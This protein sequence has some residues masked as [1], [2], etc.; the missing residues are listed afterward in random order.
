MTPEQISNMIEENR[1]LKETVR[2]MRSHLMKMGESVKILATEWR[3][4]AAENYGDVDH[5]GYE[6]RIHEQVSRYTKQ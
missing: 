4:D 1:R 2:H 5:Y 6:R 3:N